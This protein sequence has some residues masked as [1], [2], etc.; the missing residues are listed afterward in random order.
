MRFLWLRVLGFSAG[1]RGSE[2]EDFRALR[3]L[4]LGVQA[5]G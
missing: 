4:G 3:V 5:W 1:F 2:F